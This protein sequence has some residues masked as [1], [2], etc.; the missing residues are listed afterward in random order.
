VTVAYIGAAALL[1]VGFGLR[2]VVPARGALLA[3]V[4]AAILGGLVALVLRAV[5]LLP[6]SPEA[7]QDAAYHLFGV[8]FLAIGLTPSGTTRVRKG[9]IWMGVGQ[10]ATFS[11]QAAVGGLI[12]I[13][14]GS[15]HDGFGFLAPLGLNEGPGQAL[16]IGRLWEDDYGFANAASIGVT[17]ASVGFLVAYLGGLLLV[18]GRRVRTGPISHG[19]G[20]TGATVGWSV[21]LIAGYT[22]IYQAVY[23]GI[24]AMGDDVRDLVLSVLFFVCLLVGMGVRRLLGTRGITV[25]GAETRRVTLWT[26]DALTVG[27]LGSLTWEAVSGVIWP[28]TLVLVGAVAATGAVL[29][30]SGGWI[31]RWRTER[32][33]ALFGTVTGTVASGLALL[34]LVDPDLESPVAVE[35]GAMVVVSAPIVLIGIALATATASGAVALPLATAVFGSIGVLSLGVIALVVPRVA[36]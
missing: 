32:T 20:L 1:L 7:W 28:M 24:G 36:E 31:D 8:S 6:G 26:V 2:R 17:I 25:D 30:I 34:A 15:L 3:I 21:A 18:R 19:Y 11:L 13:G 23:H 33:L 29:A 22:V 5:G 27:I 14:F 12:V 9:A 16:S 10:W 4:P 35:L